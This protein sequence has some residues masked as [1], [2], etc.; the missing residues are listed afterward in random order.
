MAT[1]A[2]L[3]IADDHLRDMEML[4]SRVLLIVAVGMSTATSRGQNTSD[5]F[6]VPDDIQSVIQSRC[7]GCHSADASEGNVRLDV[8]SGMQLSERLELLNKVQEQL[9]FGLMPP[10]EEDQ[11][12]EAERAQFVAWTSAELRKQNASKLDEKL[13]RPE[14]G[15]YVD[16]DKLFSG[17]YAHLKSFTRDRRWLISEFIF[18]ATINRLIDHPGGRT[19]DGQRMDVIGDNGVNLGTRFGG[20]TLRASITN[21]FLLPTNI[22]VRY[23]DTT[24]LTGG[25]L[26]TMISNAKKVAAYMSSEQAMKAH[27][28]AMYRIMKTELAHREI[29]AS[30][31]RFLNDYIRNVTQDIYKEGNE[32]LLPEFVRTKVD[33]VQVPLDSK[34]NP[35]QKQTNMELLRTRYDR[36]DIQAIYRGIQ[37]YKQEDVSYEEV[38]EKCEQDWFNFGVHEKRLSGRVMLMMIMGVRWDMSL[39]YED[40]KKQNV[41]LPPYQPPSDSEM[42]VINS[43]I[44]KHREQGDRYRQIIDK[45]M[46]GWE[47]SFKAERVAAGQ[48]D[49]EQLGNLV[50]ELFARIYERE[51]TEQETQEN[52][53]LT[54]SYMQTLSNQEAIAKLIETLLLSSE[55]VYRSEF[56]QGPADEYGRRM[57]SP[58][59]ASYALA[60]ALTDSSPDAV[61][62]AAVSEGRFRTRED[63]R[64]E[65]A[66]MLKRRDQ[67][68]VIDETVQKAGFNASITNTPIRKLRFFRE[69]F[70]YPKAM[71]VFKDDARFGA[72]RHDGTV[73]RLV[74]ETDMLVDHIL[75]QDKHVFEELLST[76]TFYVYHSGDNAEMTAATDRL[77]AIYD[78]FKEYDWEDFT[79][80]QLYEH[81]PFIKRM[82][83]RG[84]VFPDFE[85]NERRRKDWVRSFKRTMA[86]LE[87]R[88]GRGQANAIPYDELPM[89]YWHKGNAT[90]R[91]GQVMRGH[92]VATYFN[93]DYL[94]WDYPPNQPA[95]IPNRKGLLTH[96][97][98]LIAHS[99]NLE[100]DPVRRGKWIREKLL[101]GTIPDVPIT[102]DAV[103]PGDHHKTLRQ[104][105]KKATASSY[106]WNCHEKMNPLGLPF[107]MYDDFGRFRRNERIEHPE[108]L[109]RD[110]KQAERTEG[111]Q[112][113]LYKTLPVDPRGYLSGTG[114]ES[115]DG[116]VDD[117]I[118]LCE[119]LA[120]SDR[121]RQSIIRHAFRYFLGR[122][123]GLSDSKTLID[124][125]KAYIQSGG[126]FDAVI[127]SLLAS[128]SFIY[129]R[130]M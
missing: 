75:Q 104:R 27:Y 33:E 68:Y 22:G 44:R 92:E 62:V 52:I 19:I 6:V 45:C 91:T 124:A 90:G 67:Y 85:T 12:T 9:F 1:N 48:A 130:K 39:I 129:R 60:Y 88:L 56:G 100:T 101:A 23:Y 99:L 106:C 64:R 65:V 70:G 126:S 97:A 3:W 107:E 95:K 123:E 108:N 119:R 93:V 41:A 31:E 21:P 96:P 121:V 53:A 117:A 87:E 73:S 72:G 74:D 8:L 86:S 81:W 25:H 5:S 34:G 26:L 122:N 15:N 69:F 32:A 42:Q 125:D 102:V 4:T 113:A 57:M 103:V 40:V 61:L 46:A 84:T 115:L 83:M 2:R 37:K 76:E 98:W 71:T 43:S 30:R 17:E 63:Y 29:L 105:L 78:Y 89:A 118:D 13:R 94:D 11:P 59:D 7:I 10:E 38:I 82:K 55:V 54:R 35:K 50:D 79:E 16:H 58:R 47:A 114:D 24:A 120:K 127:T 14:Y 80:E 20:H 66:R 110:A 51:A 112:V 128:D 109:L 18:D 77:R 36:Q 28:P 116:E 49:D 111:I